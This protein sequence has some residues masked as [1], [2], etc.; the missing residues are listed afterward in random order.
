MPSKPN[1]V[2]IKNSN[3]HSQ[4]KQSTNIKHALEEQD[5]DLK[6]QTLAKMECIC[7]K[8]KEEKKSGRCSTS[9][10]EMSAVDRSV[11]RAANVLF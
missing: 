10:T 9:P 4:K 1:M 7:D 6:Q 8:E 3:I 11:M 2:N 5:Q